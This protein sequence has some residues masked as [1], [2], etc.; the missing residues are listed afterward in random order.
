MKRIL[1]IM[2]VCATIL[3][4]CSCEKDCLMKNKGWVVVEKRPGNFLVERAIIIR[5][6]ENFEEKYFRDIRQYDWDLYNIGD[7]IK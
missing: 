3:T 5:N 1:L 6:T 4:L 2:T 7:T